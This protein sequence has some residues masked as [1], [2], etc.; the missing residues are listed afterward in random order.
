MTKPFDPNPL[1][2]AVIV[3]EPSGLFLA[4]ITRKMRHPL[5][6]GFYY[7]EIQGYKPR[8][9]KTWL[10]ADTSTRKYIAEL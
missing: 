8:R 9:F 3:Q 1:H 4:S 6:G 5:T 10:G 7:V 2:K